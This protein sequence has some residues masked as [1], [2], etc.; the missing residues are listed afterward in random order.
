MDQHQAPKPL[1]REVQTDQCQESSFDSEKGLGDDLDGHC[2]MVFAN[3]ANCN[4]WK[5]NAYDKAELDWR[6]KPAAEF[7]AGT[8]MLLERSLPLELGDTH[9]V[10]SSP[11]GFQV[12]RRSP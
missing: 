10:T 7:F 1:Q 4:I 6:A 8:P 9:P 3:R 11:D 5:Q 2:R 12:L